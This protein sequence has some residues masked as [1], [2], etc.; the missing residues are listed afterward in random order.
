VV[1]QP[2]SAS[3][4]SL[5]KLSHHPTFDSAHG[6]RQL[7]AFNLLSALDHE[8]WELVA[9]VDMSMGSAECKLVSFH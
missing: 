8:G 1:V 2:R 3:H 7:L 4:S 6:S 9:S 5:S